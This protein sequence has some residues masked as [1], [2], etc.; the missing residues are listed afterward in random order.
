MKV[1]SVVSTRPELI[2]MAPVMR[3]IEAAG[4]EHVFISTG[5]HYDL[6]LFGGIIA[7]LELP[8][9]D[10]NYALASETKAFEINA[11][12]AK[13]E[14]T[15][16][17][18]SPDVVL[19]EGDTN[20]ILASALAAKNLSVPF[21]H[22]EAGLRSFDEKMPEE[23]NRAATDRIS[24]WLFAPTETSRKNL[25][26]EGMIK[27]VH[28]VGN[29]IVDAALQHIEIAKRKSKILASHQ[30][31]TKDYILATLHRQE[32]VDD[33]KRLASALE[34]LKAIGEKTGKQV[35]LPIHPRTKKRASE[36]GFSL[37]GLNIIEP[38]GYLDFLCLENNASL[39]LTDSGGLQE[40]ACILKVPC[41]TMRDNTERPETVEA[42]A[43]IVAGVEKA[44]VLRAVEEMMRR[45]RDWSNPFGDGTTG[46][47]I[48]EILKPVS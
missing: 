35:L 17:K 1:L 18:H 13:I 9:L 30:L 45:R 28:V 27:G 25:E 37:A 15:I 23:R 4:I 38:V 3:E 34:S 22:V 26:K 10:E 24:T 21:G 19:A 14:A 47:K 31:Q 46:K 16:K 8:A 29:S 12:V 40:E 2:K 11:A 7:D 44:S 48:V 41:V 5:Q 43:N 39:I 42:G 20:S 33:R 6:K 36:F 32:N